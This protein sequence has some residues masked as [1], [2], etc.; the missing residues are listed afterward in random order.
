MKEKAKAALDTAAATE[1][2]EINN[3]PS[4]TAKEKA[5]KV[6]ELEAKVAE[7]KDKIDQA[8]NAQGVAAAKT[9]GEEAIG[10]FH[11]NGNLQAVKDAAKTALEK[12]AEKET[13]EINNDGS[14][15]DTEKADKVRELATKLAEEKGKI[16]AAEITNAD[17]VAEAKK[18]GEKAIDDVHKLGEVKHEIP[19]NAPSVE[20][21]EYTGTIGSTGVDENGNLITP[22]TVE[23][24]EYTGPV[25]TTGVDENGELIQPPVVEKPEYTG[26]VGTTGM[27]ENGELI[28][29]PVVE[30]PEYIGPVG[31]TGVDENGELIQP[32]V[33]EKPE[34][35][36]PVATTGVDE[37]RNLMEPPIV[38]IPEYKGPIG[39]TGVDENGNLLLP[40]LLHVPEFN[41]GVNG[42]LSDPVESPKVKLIITRWT[43]EDGKELK[44]PDAKAPKVLGEPNEALEAGEIEGYEFVRT[45]TKDDVVTHIFRKVTSTKLTKPAD[46]GEEQGGDNKP[47]PTPTSSKVDENIKPTLTAKVEKSTKRLANTGEA[48]TNTGLAGLGLAVLGSLL[49]VAKRRK[50]DEE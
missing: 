44:A 34:Y 5:A 3:D 14:L 19:N 1:K 4:L 46:N 9:A 41:G 8:P 2:D 23:I 33:V 27:D 25:G 37:N 18:A 45:E 39:T 24:P 29:P 12:A 40:P 49:A 21:P 17:Q 50:K 10:N 48:E 15:T 26:P 6:K 32:P 47:Q 35:T 11:T 22:P 36:G 30:K 28:Q 13:A 20:V 38:E 7:E 42:E 16:D 31:T 43:D